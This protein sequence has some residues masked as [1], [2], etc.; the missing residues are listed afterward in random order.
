MERSAFLERLRARL[1]AEEAQADVLLRA[2]LPEHH[3]LDSRER[4]DLFVDRLRELGV[5]VE[6]VTSQQDAR[7]AVERLMSERAWQSV[8]CASGLSWQGI[9]K[10][11]IANAREAAF[12]LSEADWAVAETGTVV[13][14]SS[15]DERRDYSLLP[16]AVGF[17][18]PQRRICET[19]G[20]VLREIAAD[21]RP[22]PSCLSFISGPSS[23]ADIA[24]VHVVGVH[25]PGEVFVWVIA[26]GSGLS[27]D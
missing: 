20:D 11:R 19:L 23:T 18:V 10:Q 17:I 25:G 26:E 5:E 6:T 3:G 2:N 1:T 7:D 13:M 24:S 14:R 9:A 16:P 4:I 27:G 15:A 8:A 12:G 22:L 21:E